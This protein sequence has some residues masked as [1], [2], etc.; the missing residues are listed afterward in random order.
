MNQASPRLPPPIFLVKGS[1]AFRTY[2]LFLCHISDCWSLCI[3]VRRV[4][5]LRRATPLLNWVVGN[6]FLWQLLF[7]GPGA[8]SRFF[9]YT[10]SLVL[11][12]RFTFISRFPLP[13][14]PLLSF[15]SISC[16]LILLSHHHSFSHPFF[17]VFVCGQKKKN[18]AC[19]IILVLNC[20][21]QLQIKILNLSRGTFSRSVLQAAAAP[22][23]GE[24][25]LT[26]GDVNP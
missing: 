13:F 1:V 7:A 2:V 16:S 19:F 26:A 24:Q 15:L 25:A 8:K 22:L 10:F 5:R 11:F 9:A 4:K 14:V 21:P 12:D 17:F 20:H 23:E 3:S 18:K 6:P